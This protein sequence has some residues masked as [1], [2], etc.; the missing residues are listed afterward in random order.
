[1][2]DGWDFSLFTCLKKKKK[3][4]SFQLCMEIFALKTNNHQIQSEILTDKCPSDGM[5]LPNDLMLTK[6]DIYKVCFSALE[7]TSVFQKQKSGMTY[8]W[9]YTAF[10]PGLLVNRGP[11]YLLCLEAFLWGLM[12]RSFPALSEWEPSANGTQDPFCTDNAGLC[13]L[14]LKILALWSWR[15]VTG[16]NMNLL[17]VFSSPI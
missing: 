1:M 8:E 7:V 16:W 14:A 6:L 3:K 13:T 5:I 4:E 2:I 11:S 15:S 10:M 17:P 9:Y 12:L